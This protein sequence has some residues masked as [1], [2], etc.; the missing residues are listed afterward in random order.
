MP[1]LKEFIDAMGASWP[2]ALAACI[3]SISILVGEGFGISYLATLP[4]LVFGIAFLIAAFSGA[5]LIVA[6]IVKS[7]AG[8]EDHRTRRRRAEAKKRHI[9]ALNNLPDEEKAVL[10]YVASCRTQVFLASMNHNRLEPLIAKG[11]V[12]VVRGMHSVVDWP[13][14]VPDHIW[15]ELLLLV[16]ETQNKRALHNPL[17]S[18]W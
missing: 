9:A 5:V 8:I 11:Y 7:I 13:H 3:G 17:A 15:N 6:I 16:P 12:E 2:V 14:K 10:N 4:R 18:R 1:G